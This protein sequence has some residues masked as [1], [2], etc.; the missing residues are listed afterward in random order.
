MEDWQEKHSYT[1]LVEVISWKCNLCG[2]PPDSTE[3]KM[4]GFCVVQ[5]P[6]DQPSSSHRLSLGVASSHILEDI[7]DHISSPSTGMRLKKDSKL[8]PYPGVRSR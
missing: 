5:D 1:D 4:C 7:D 6:D 3:T 8:L 2:L